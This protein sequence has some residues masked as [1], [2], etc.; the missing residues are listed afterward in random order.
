MLS[1]LLLPRVR[2]GLARPRGACRAILLPGRWGLTAPAAACGAGL[3]R[4]LA[5]FSPCS[6][7]PSGPSPQTRVARPLLLAPTVP[8]ITQHRRPL[9]CLPHLRPGEQGA[10]TF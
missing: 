5:P 1:G 9:S 7:Q 6:H 3:L 2:F 10:G 4:A 8:G